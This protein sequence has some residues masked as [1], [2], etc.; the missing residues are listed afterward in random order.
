[1]KLLI[2]IITCLLAPLSVSWSQDLALFDSALAQVG[3]SHSDVQLDQGEMSTWGGDQ[4]RL[5]YFTMLH[6]SPFKLPKYGQMNLEALTAE[7]GNITSLVTDG[8]RKID[9]PVRRLLIGNPLERYI[10][11]KDSQPLSSFTSRRNL[12]TGQKYRRLRSRL[13]LFFAVI[14]D[15]DFNFTKA[16]HGLDKSKF[17]KD[18][19]QYFVSD[20]QQY[21]DLAEKLASQLDLNR[22]VA[23][24][25]DI[26]EVLRQM[27][28][29]LEDCVFP[30]TRT[31]FGTREGLII[32][33]TRDSDEYE[34]ATPPLLILDPGGDD[35]YRISG[36]PTQ[37]PLCA[38]IDVAGN[39]R[40]LS[41]D[42]TSPGI[43]GAILGMSVVIDKSGEDLY[44][45]KN[46]A[47]GCG[48]FGVGVVM[49]YNGNDRYRAKAYSQGAGTFGMGILSDSTGNDSLYCWANSQGYGYTK[50]CGFCINYSGN[51]VYIAE[52]SIIFSPGQ[53][54]K[55]HNSSLAQGVG[56]G[57]RADYVDGHSWAGGVGILCDISGDDRYS[58][59]LF[60]QGCGYWFGLG[61]LLDG[62]GDDNY[63]S[64]WYTLGSGAHFAV[65]YFDD[66]L[67]NDTYN[68]TMNMSIGSGHDFTVGYFNERAGND[69]YY[70]PGLSLGG[71]NF[72]GI[73]I[74]DDWAGDDV[75]NTSGGFNLGGARGLLQGARAYL[76]TFGIFVDGGGNDTYSDLRVKNG[77]LWISPKSDTTKPDPN[78]IGVG[79]DR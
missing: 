24:A 79:V 42:S 73:G 13:D 40:Y 56:F 14:T 47:Q 1:M 75:Y 76:R 15:A 3:L 45:A 21:N 8:G 16:Y 34:Y 50:G 59:G 60:A 43:G 26:A 66:F 57:K 69:V 68:V 32:L 18:L 30:A 74:F 71:G 27:S 9:C 29:S 61:M 35:T 38:I 7:C 44:E 55:E 20:S 28:D 63:L 49:D 4:W 22:V 25:E 6:T 5:T 11:P 17:R 37:Y 52:D 72:Q 36:S 23:G 70:A 58:A 67:G 62:S 77:M 33:G 12:L 2:I 39:D 41:A 64:A 65:G 19:F 10:N 51:D 31:E 78:E 54:T 53:Q 46:V 48:I